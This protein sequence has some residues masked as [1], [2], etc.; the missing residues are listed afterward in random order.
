MKNNLPWNYN[1]DVSLKDQSSDE[2]SNEVQKI[3]KVSSVVTDNEIKRGFWYEPKDA[4][5]AY[6]MSDQ[7]IHP[8]FLR[9]RSYYKPGNM[10]GMSKS[11]L[12]LLKDENSV[13]TEES[14]AS[15]E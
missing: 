7:S 10:H 15:E 8:V 5:H 2:A 9:A 13:V 14:T 3:I 6:Y 11:K 1:Y 4:T 12:E